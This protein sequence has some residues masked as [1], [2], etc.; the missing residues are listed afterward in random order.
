M[1]HKEFFEVYTEIISKSCSKLRDDRFAAIVVGEVRDKKGCYVDLVGRTVQA[2][3][4]AGLRYYNEA[5]LV[6]AVGS[7][8]MR[9]TRQ[10]NAGRKMGKTHQNILIFVKGDSKKAT[11][12][13]EKIKS[14]L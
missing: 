12:R 3:E 5:V 11:A 2:F 6:T 7:L 9:L 10:F 1:T 4:D 8:A 14:D 13:L